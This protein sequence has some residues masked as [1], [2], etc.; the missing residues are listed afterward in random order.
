MGLLKDLVDKTVTQLTGITDAG[1]FG[2]PA[3]TDANNAY[4]EGNLH[5][6][7]KALG[8][9][10]SPSKEYFVSPAFS[11]LTE[12]NHFSSLALAHAQIVT[13]GSGSSNKALIS[14]GANASSY[15]DALTLNHNGYV[16][17]KG[18][19]KNNCVISGNIVISTGTYIFDDVRFEDDITVS[20][21]KA[22]FL[23]CSKPSGSFTQSGS[24]STVV[25]TDCDRWS[26]IIVTGNDKVIHARNIRDMT[27]NTGISISLAISMTGG[28]YVF[29]DSL[30]QGTIDEKTAATNISNVQESFIALPTY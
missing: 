9:A 26:Y 25:I 20:G 5:N 23:N 4:F 30:L 3:G 24:A 2:D 12:V 15:S 1:Y 16:V 8:I 21:G 17:I 11:A 22:I 29:T 27:A 19:S 13:D 6:Y 18:K 7:L 10:A 28:T 14:L